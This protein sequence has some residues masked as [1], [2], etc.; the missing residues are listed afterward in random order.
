MRFLFLYLHLFRAIG[1]VAGNAE[2]GEDEISEPI[3]KSFRV[4]FVTIECPRGL[5][6]AEGGGWGGGDVVEG[7]WEGGD[8]GA[9]SLLGG[10]RLVGSGWW[11]MASPSSVLVVCLLGPGWRESA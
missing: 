10:P 11:S 3:E 6:M 8:D 1:H 9:C 2:G 5:S 4:K 7:R